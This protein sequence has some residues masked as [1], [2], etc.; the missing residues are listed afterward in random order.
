MKNSSQW[1]EIIRNAVRWLIRKKTVLIDADFT[2]GLVK[3]Y[4][5]GIGCEI[6]PGANP[7]TDP[8]STYF[9]D[10]HRTYMNLAINVDV[11]ADASSLP[12]SSESLDFLVSSHVLEHCPDTLAALEEWLR[13]L[14]RGGRLVLRL[15]HGLRTFDRGRA[16]TTL[17]HHIQDYEDHVDSTDRTHWEEFARIS[18]PGFA[19]HWKQDA[20][21]ADGSYDLEYVVRY[22]HMHYHVWTQTEMIDVLRHLNCPILFVMDTPL[23]RNDSF[24][25]VCEKP[26]RA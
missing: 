25:I 1:F 17:E 11:V 8:A 15:P 9:V 21:R 13:V 24:C 2:R 6:G 16:F 10:R 3:R 7:Q 14:K 20:L 12:F 22:G 23:D 26:L 5:A 4:C 19:H 18:I